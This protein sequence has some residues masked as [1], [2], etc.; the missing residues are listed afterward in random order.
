[1]FYYVSFLRPPPTHVALGTSGITITPQI[2][3]DLRTELYPEPQDVYYAW[4]PCASSV[5]SPSAP[6][7][8]SSKPAKLTTWRSGHAYKEVLVPPPHGARDGQ[9]Y[10][11][12]LTAHAQ[13]A[14][15]IVN[16][17]GHGVGGRPFP[18]MSMPIV[19]G[20]GKP[21]AGAGKQE[22]VE[23]IYRVAVAGEQQ[24]FMSIREKTSFDLDKVRLELAARVRSLISEYNRKY[25]T[26]GSA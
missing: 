9:A 25:G 26:V 14:P 2:A 7:Q 20:R 1:M 6:L 22:Q 3:N 4:A 10:R 11:L 16:L 15:H 18:V 21:P 23:R 8:I 24:A 17:A 12:V 5:I 19:F 13:G